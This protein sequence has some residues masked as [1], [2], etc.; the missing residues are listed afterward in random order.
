MKTHTAT[1]QTSSNNSEASKCVDMKESDNRDP[2]RI[3]DEQKEYYTKQFVSMQ[4]SHDGKIDGQTARNFFTKSKLPIIELS[5][6]WELSDIDQDGLLTLDEFCI[7]FH[8]VVARKNGYELPATLPQS[9]TVS[10]SGKDK[11]NLG[12]DVDNTDSVASPNATEKNNDS[13]WECFNAAGGESIAKFQET[14][15]KNS[16][17][18]HHPVAIRLGPTP[19]KSAGRKNKESSPKHET[20]DDE[21]NTSSPHVV[22]Q[23]DT[24][25][26]VL[27]NETSDA[28]DSDDDRKG[29]KSSMSPISFISNHSSDPDEQQCEELQSDVEL[30]DWSS[31]PLRPKS[32]SSLE[33][34]TVVEAATAAV[35][36]AP[37]PPPRPSL[38]FTEKEP[39][40]VVVVD[41]KVTIEKKEVPSLPPRPSQQQPQSPDQEF[42][43]D[44][45][46]FTAGQQPSSR[47]ENHHSSAAAATVTAAADNS[48]VEEQPSVE[49]EVSSSDIQ[50]STTI[51]ATTVTAIDVTEEDTVVAGPAPATP[52]AVVVTSKEQ[53]ETKPAPEPKAQPVKKPPPTKP[54][55]KRTIGGD[56]AVISPTIEDEHKL[57]PA[58]S[59]DLSRKKSQIEMEIRRLK[60]KSQQ[61]SR[62]NGDLQ[63]Q[64]KDVMEE[65]ILV[66][67][68]I[69][70]LR[71]FTE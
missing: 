41:A 8:L 46:K 23:K 71:P 68:N 61:L 21:S 49:Q 25:Y 54:P 62:L 57:A 13:E 22:V 30:S 55:R 44:F 17:E 11:E 36:T 4:S 66:E 33:S 67:M 28:D 27:R 40:T 14:P 48:S 69:H 63:R 34:L 9:L 16:N 58:P 45:S 6:I 38:P 20:V 60:L 53:I 52:A 50:S 29:S 15:G 12:G 10:S 56:V 7:A 18:L 64:L 47:V 32:D 37:T 42:F 3:T 5:H 59:Q 39:T 35:P 1:S 19:Q 70:K 43:A 31:R 24:P 65:R 51:A 2:W 26:G